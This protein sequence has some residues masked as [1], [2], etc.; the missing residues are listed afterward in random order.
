MITSSSFYNQ[1][2]PAAKKIGKMIQYLFFPPGVS[3][4]SVSA[5]V[6]IQSFVSKLWDVGH[7]CTYTFFCPQ[8]SLEPVPSMSHAEHCELA[9]G[10]GRL[11]NG[12]CY[13]I[14]LRLY[15]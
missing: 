13:L 4:S 9:M 1:E 12:C 10:I 8:S 15:L 3:L 2:N 5:H 7:L 14:P 11:C 6:S